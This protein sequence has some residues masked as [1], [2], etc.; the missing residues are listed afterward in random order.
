MSDIARCGF[1]ALH[2][3]AQRFAPP[4]LHLARLPACLT[5]RTHAHAVPQHRR[6]KAEAVAARSTFPS[7]TLCAPRTTPWLT[8]SFR[9][10]QGVNPY[11]FIERYLHYLFNPLLT[12]GFDA[13]LYVLWALMG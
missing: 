13:Q 2:Y 7:A 11:L 10:C 5:T 6:S 1:V 4:Q 12:P 9:R 8:C 3:P